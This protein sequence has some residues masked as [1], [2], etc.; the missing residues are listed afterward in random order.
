MRRVPDRR[1]DAA[2]PRALGPL[3]RAHRARRSVREDAGAVAQLDGRALQRLPHARHGRRGAEHR[4]PEAPAGPHRAE[5]RRSESRRPSEGGRQGNEGS[6]H[7][8]RTKVRPRRRRRR[9][10]RHHELHEHVEPGRHGRRGTRGAQRRGERPHAQTVGQDE[11]GAG[12]EGRQRL[13]R[14]LRARRRPRQAGVQPRRL[15]LHHMHRQ[16]WSVARRDRSGA[17]EERR[18]RLLRALR[19]P[20]F[21]GPH[22]PAGQDEFPGVA[23]ARRRVRDRR[24]HEARSVQGSAR[25]RQGRQ[26]R[27]LARHLAV[28]EEIRRRSTT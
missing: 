18:R 12:L 22:P 11:L 25:G 9:H 23:A 17:A 19:Q 8:R 5:R 28:D 20:Q 10:C 15:R 13:S 24:Q 3:A 2:L 7:G 26:A 21:R 1:R 6:R 4:G 27:L 14:R 16:C